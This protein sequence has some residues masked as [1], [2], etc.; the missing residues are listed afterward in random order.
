MGRGVRSIT[1]TV[2][3]GAAPVQVYDALVNPRTHAAFTGAP[4]TGRARVG[5]TFTA[6]GGYITGI[7]RTLVPGQ[8]IVQEWWTTEWPEGAAPSILELTL[9]TVDGG[10]R[11]RM[12]HS[13]VPAEQADGYRQGWIDHYWTPLKAYFSEGRAPAGTRRG[14]R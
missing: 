10:T 11:V 4:A 6:W 9:T 5:S 13:K 7:H 14:S 3:I 8:S 1:Q 2:T 12:V